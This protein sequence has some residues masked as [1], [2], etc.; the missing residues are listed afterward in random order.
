MGKWTVLVFALALSACA[1]RSDSDSDSSSDKD[2]DVMCD[3]IGWWADPAKVL[4]MTRGGTHEQCGQACW[5]A[6]GCVGYTW[7]S[8]APTCV[9]FAST[10]NRFDICTTCLS[11]NRECFRSAQREEL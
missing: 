1:V 7:E 6:E 2:H 10:T 8:S 11:G 5:H 3:V 9:L 4:E